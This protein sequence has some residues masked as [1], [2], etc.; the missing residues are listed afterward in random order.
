MKLKGFNKFINESFAPID[1]ELYEEKQIEA[2]DLE[3]IPIADREF[4]TEKDE[5]LRSINSLKWESVSGSKPMGY[6]LTIKETIQEFKIPK[7]DQIAYGGK[8]GR[9]HV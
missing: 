2:K 3:W 9:A 1:V 4:P 5:I 7:V 8:I 6:G